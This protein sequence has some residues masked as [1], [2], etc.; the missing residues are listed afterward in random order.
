MSDYSGGVLFRKEVLRVWHEVCVRVAHAGGQTPGLGILTA[1]PSFHF[2][3]HAKTNRVE[4]VNR[5]TQIRPRG[6]TAWLGLY[7][8]REV[9][10]LR[11]VYERTVKDDLIIPPQITI[12]DIYA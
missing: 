2:C 1:T 5:H 6:V 12:R 3:Y 9:P 11:T 8:P 10:W 4:I 7:S